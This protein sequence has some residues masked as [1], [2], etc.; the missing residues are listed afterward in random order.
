ML[1]LMATPRGEESRPARLAPEERRS[2]LVES[3]LGVFARRGFA[4]AGTRDLARAAGALSRSGADAPLVRAVETARLTLSN[5]SNGTVTA[6]HGHR[7][8]LQ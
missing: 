4:G 3:A 2:Q 6:E 8:W 7:L 5:N 1:A